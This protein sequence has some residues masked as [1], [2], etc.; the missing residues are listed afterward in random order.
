MYAPPELTRSRTTR[1]RQLMA[2]SRTER[3]A[4][5]AFNADNLETI[6]AICRAAHRLAAPVFVELS[7]A[8]VEVLGLAN[9][10]D[11][12]DNMIDDLGVEVYLNL[13]HAPTVRDA[14]AAIDAG[15]ELIHI[16]IAQAD[17][18]ATDDDI[19]AATREVV[20]FARRTGA[21][22]EGELR[23]LA[24]SS[25]LHQEPVDMAAVR[26]SLSTPEGAIA[27]VD[28]TG[29]DTFAVGIGNIHGRY[30]TSKD[31][32]LDLLARI[33]AA[34]DVNI[35]LHGGSGTPE[36]VY[37]RLARGGVGKIN[38]NSDA[39]Y[40]YRSTLEQQFATHPD[41]YATAKLIRPVIDAIQDAVETKIRAFGSAGKA[42]P[43]VH[44]D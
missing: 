6:S 20:T 19:I 35:S 13:D 34:I 11:V 4:V 14:V 41:E 10:R 33:R 44:H 43:G 21:L 18:Q 23:Y 9:V 40:A 17:H 36:P 24:G 2:R 5:G 7:H 29:I 16:D 30:R 37:R 27:F 22:V 15:Y 31:L 3:F 28:A 38:I 26:S 1:A 39:R 42:Q 8:E 32:D 12:V 25:T